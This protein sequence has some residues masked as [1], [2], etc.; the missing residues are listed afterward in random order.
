MYLVSLFVR[1]TNG[2]NVVCLVFAAGMLQGGV[3]RGM[4]EDRGNA[5]DASIVRVM[6]ARK[7]LAHS[8]LQ[9]EVLRQIT[10]FQPDVKLIKQR[11]ES[12]IERGFL[13]RDEN[14]ARLYKYMP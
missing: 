11:V 14:D 2:R 1:C 7:L 3:S 5:V 4:Q 8:D 10:G 6:K 12:L 13:E 9:Y